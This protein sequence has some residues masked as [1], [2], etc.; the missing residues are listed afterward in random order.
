MA[1]PDGDK[2]LPKD[3]VELWELVV[4]YFKQETVGPLKNLRRF[5]LLGV[6]GSFCLGIG[7]VV[8]VIAALR[9]MQAETGAHFRQNLSWVPYAIMIVV[10][11]SIAGA[12]MAVWARSGNPGKEER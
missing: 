9:V 4:A 11:L 7:L 3:I 5:V 2:S 8:L 12:A 1:T 10:C 6:L